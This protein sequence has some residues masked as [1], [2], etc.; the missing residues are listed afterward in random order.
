M[1]PL[2]WYLR[3]LGWKASILCWKTDLFHLARIRL[4]AKDLGNSQSQSGPQCMSLKLVYGEAWSGSTINTWGFTNRTEVKSALRKPA[5]T[6]NVFR[7]HG[8]VLNS[9][10][11]QRKLFKSYTVCAATQLTYLEVTLRV[12][13]ERKPWL[14]LTFLF[15]LLYA[16]YF[17]SALFYIHLFFSKAFLYFVCNSLVIM[18]VAG[19]SSKS[20][21]DVND[22]TLLKSMER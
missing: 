11:Q 17:L 8:K 3:G 14:H 9:V 13:P 19:S 6:L 18:H 5:E 7:S 1:Q 4:L 16:V 15:N 12:E 2:C 22:K 21:F 10:N 20:S